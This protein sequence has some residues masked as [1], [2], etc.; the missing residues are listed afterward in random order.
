MLAAQNTA[1]ENKNDHVPS[2]QHTFLPE[3]E[4]V[5]LNKSVF[6]KSYIRHHSL[7][8]LQIFCC[9]NQLFSYH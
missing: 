1:L 2:M 4:K 5:L 8:M 9:F 3:V 7:I 6:S